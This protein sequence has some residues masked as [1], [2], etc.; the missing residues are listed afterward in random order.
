MA[1]VSRS[2]APGASDEEADP[3]RAVGLGYPIGTMP[4]PVLLRTA[5]QR[6][7]EPEAVCCTN[8]LRDLIRSGEAGRLRQ[9]AG[10]SQTT[11]GAALGVSHVMVGYIENRRHPVPWRL[12]PSYYRKIGRASCRE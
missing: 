2:H 12:Q 4:A 3:R 7:E 1:A 5:G 10:I 9:A 6:T 11:M 8:E